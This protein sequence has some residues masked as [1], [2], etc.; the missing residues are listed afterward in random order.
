MLLYFNFIIEFRISGVRSF[1]LKYLKGKMKR[2][3][4]VCQKKH[5]KR[6][7]IIKRKV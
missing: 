1:C 5:S 3:K 4:I 7:G 6:G 2:V